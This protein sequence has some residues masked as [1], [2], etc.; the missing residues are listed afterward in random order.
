MVSLPD[1]LAPAD[2]RPA[3]WQDAASRRS[4]RWALPI[5]APEAVFSAQLSLRVE[6]VRAGAVVNVPAALGL[7]DGAR[8]QQAQKQGLNPGRSFIRLD[9]WEIGIDTLDNHIYHWLYKPK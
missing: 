9:N 1:G 7:D 6:G 2:D 8:L 5:L 4:L 3:A